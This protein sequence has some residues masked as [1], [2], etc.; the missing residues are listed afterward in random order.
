MKKLSGLLAVAVLLMSVSF[1]C[2]EKVAPFSERIAKIWVPRIVLE[3]GNTVYSNGGS[4]NLKP[5]YAS[6]RL[7]LSSPPQA[8]LTEV[9]GQTYSGTYTINGESSLTIS[10]ISPEPTG[11]SGTLEYSINSLSETS[12]ELVITLNTLYAKTGNTTNKYTLLP[13]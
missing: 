1:S 7:N 6:Y 10:G 5:S 12:D 11:T 2:K 4:N 13:Q 3:N 8:T 9:D